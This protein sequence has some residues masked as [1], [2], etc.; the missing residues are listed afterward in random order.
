[1]CP[2]LRPFKFRALTPLW[3]RGGSAI[4]V[5]HERYKSYK[6]W[7]QC[8]VSL[9]FKVLLELMRVRSADSVDL[10]E[11]DFPTMRPN[12]HPRSSDLSQTLCYDV[13]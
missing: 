3:L 1:M 8:S 4:G 13:C 5:Q 7:M 9:A 6:G 11:V 2:W 12:L 10:N